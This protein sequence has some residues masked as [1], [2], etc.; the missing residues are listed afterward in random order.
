MSA[1]Q[2]RTVMAHTAK[3][4]GTAYVKT[5]EKWS[6]SACCLCGCTNDV[7]SSR[8]FVCGVCRCTLH[9]DGKA[10]A[11]IRL[12][13]DHTV[14]LRLVRKAKAK[15]S[16]VPKAQRTEQMTQALHA[17]IAAANTGDVQ[18][19]RVE[20]QA[21]QRRMQEA[22]GIAARGGGRGRGLGGQDGGRDSGGGHDDDDDEEGEA[23][24]EASS[25]EDGGGG[26]DV[27]GEGAV[28]SAGAGDERGDGTRRTTRSIRAIHAALRQSPLRL[29]TAQGGAAPRRGG[30]SG[31]QA[32]AGGTTTLPGLP[33]A[34]GS[35]GVPLAEGHPLPGGGAFAGERGPFP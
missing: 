24:S 27:V 1:Y 25:E 10:G 15:L 9:R 7:G 18:T 5:P 28:G 34:A 2:L 3:R 14:A 17:A 22:R 19:V 26:G 8:E 32:R 12:T 21:M 13:A 11:V 20:L 16:R 6:T 35:R 30:G 29:D 33:A 4:T 31:G 23:S